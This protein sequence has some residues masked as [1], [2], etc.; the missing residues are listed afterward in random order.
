[1]IKEEK[2]RTLKRNM[3]AISVVCVIAFS[4]L[5][6]FAIS[7]VSIQPPVSTVDVG[8][9]FDVFVNISSVS[10][11]YAFQFD[12]GFD[13]AILSAIDVT[14]GPFL[15]SGGTTSFFPGFIDNAAGTISFTA[16]TLIGAISGV[17]GDG[18]LATLSFHAFALGTSPVDLS[19]VILLDSTLADI[20]FDTVGAS[21]NVVPEPATFIL[22]GCGL[23]SAS[24]L[25]KRFKKSRV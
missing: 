15:P 7:T 11:L 13:P 21:V 4:P 5:L 14:E 6:A 1:M 19:N 9:F 17:S 20:S 25:K 18:T 10:D 23:L 22:L 8:S 24:V 2:M 3:L 12:I 16:D